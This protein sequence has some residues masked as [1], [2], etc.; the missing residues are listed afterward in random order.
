MDPH[1]LLERVKI[2]AKVLIP[3]VKALEAELGR[4]RA[5]ALVGRAI[6]ESHAAAM[7]RKTARDRELNR[8]REAEAQR[9]AVAAQVQQLIENNRLPRDDADV[10]CQFEDGGKIR[11]IYVTSS[12]HKQLSEDRLSIVKLKARYELV[13]ADVA[14][15][16]LAE[17]SKG[18]DGLMLDLHGAMVTET[19]EDGEGELLKRIKNVAPKLPVAVPLDM[20]ANL[21]EA[22]IQYADVITGYHTY[23][24]VDGFEAAERAGSILI[25][26]IKGDVKPVMVWNGK[27]ISAN[28]GH[29]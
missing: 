6:A 23:P 13:P 26:T 17:I 22:M 27:L 20:H 12:M 18:C 1:P 19:Y 11:R 9:K 14:E 25:Q 7:A 21:Y 5:H 15:K 16:I 8:Q 29:A 3:V 4:E 10:A 28:R 24:H 2:Q